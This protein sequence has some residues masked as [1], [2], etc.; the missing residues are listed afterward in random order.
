MGVQD[1]GSNLPVNS[2]WFY[3]PACIPEIQMGCRQIT[4]AEGRKE[5]VSG[6]IS[7]DTER[8]NLSIATAHLV[9]QNMHIYQCPCLDWYETELCICRTCEQE[10]IW[11][12][13]RTILVSFCLL[14]TQ[15]GN[16]Q[17]KLTLTLTCSLEEPRSTCESMSK[18]PGILD[19]YHQI[20]WAYLLLLRNLFKSEASYLKKGLNY[21][22]IGRF[23]L[24]FSANIFLH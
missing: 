24:F 2:I 20:F 11:P 7:Q 23:I 14:G 13:G 8:V 18:T 1:K 19:G 6:L 16:R 4:V 21:K 9:L 10:Q 17:E 3:S 22:V 15:K 12:S 5:F